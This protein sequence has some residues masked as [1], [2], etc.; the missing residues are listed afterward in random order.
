MGC[1]EANRRL[2]ENVRPV[3]HG[4]E[5]H[6]MHPKMDDGIAAGRAMYHRVF[7]KR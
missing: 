1:Y 6:P 7:K 3:M 4:T 5:V 2:K